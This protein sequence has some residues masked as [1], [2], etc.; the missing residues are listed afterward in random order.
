M[1]C[2]LVASGHM[3]NVFYAKRY[4]DRRL[5]LDCS[6][7]QKNK[8][9]DRPCIFVM[10]IK[11]RHKTIRSKIKCITAQI[12]LLAL[13]FTSKQRSKT[14]IT[15]KENRPKQKQGFKFLLRKI[16]TLSVT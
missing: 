9:S 16:L 4:D 3:S 5:F 6:L 12:N 10:K 13:W 1:D 2:L 8:S 14:I 7:A 15:P 11:Q